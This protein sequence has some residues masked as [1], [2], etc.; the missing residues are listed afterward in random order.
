MDAF[1]SALEHAAAIRRGDYSSEELTRLYLDRIERFNP[2]LNHYV[3]VTAELA[4][5]MARSGAGSGALK[6][7]PVSIKDMVSLAGFPT[8]FGSRALS[9]LELPYDEY[10]VSRLKEAGCPILGKTNLSEFGTRPV[11]EYG[12][13]GAAHNPWNRKHTTGGSSGGAAGAVAAGLCAFAQG[14]D[15]G[16]SVRI[17]ASCCGVVGLKP[18]RGVISPGPVFGEGWAGLS[19]A[20]VIA[21]TV[22]DVGAA[23]DAVAG[24]LSGDPFWA[25]PDAAPRPGPL[26]VGFTT[27]AASGVDPEVAAA[28][29]Q[30]AE[31][32]ALLG[33]RVTEEGPDTSPFAEGMLAIVSAGMASLPLP[34]DADLDPLNKLSIAAGNNLTAGDYL[35]AL[36][37]IREHSRQVVAFWDDHDVL[38]TPTLTRTAPR[39]G[40]LG[41][42]LETAHEEYLDW[43]SF[44]Y[45]YNCTGQPA[46]S[47]PL[48]MSSDGLPIGIQLVGPPRGERTILALAAELEQALPWKERRPPG[49]WGVGRAQAS[50]STADRGDVPPPSR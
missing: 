41:A 8:T 31:T 48:A 39:I 44:T 14:S 16:G 3:L 38:I 32:V 4:L 20:G 43:L 1:A 49:S 45:P 13:F 30:A 7:V 21:R 29:R 19:T 50:P 10:V 9:F 17:P 46:I 5:E 24:H 35:R 40:T 15:G 26:R 37:R 25:E 27:S 36:G 33:H 11:T 23:L 34:P 28:T 12:L 47:V 6:G 2:D 18:T 42:T 22:A